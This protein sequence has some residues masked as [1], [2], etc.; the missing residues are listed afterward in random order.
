M[1]RKKLS[2]FMLATAIGVG[3]IALTGCG[4]DTSK[5]NE[6]ETKKDT[7][8]VDLYGVDGKTK[9]ESIKVKSGEKI[10]PK[11]PQKDGY[12]FVAWYLT[13]N[14]ERRADLSKPIT[15]NM[16]LYAGLAKKQ[17]DTRTFYVVGSG[18][19]DV[20]K[21]SNWG[22]V[23][24]DAQKLEKKTVDG[25]NVYT[26][27]M[28]LKEGDQF[29]FAIDGS[30]ANQRGYGYFETNKKDGKEYFKNS[31]SL[32]NSSLKKSNIEVKVDGKYT[33]TLTTYPSDDYY[34]KED[35]HYKEESKENF[36][37]NPY[38]TITFDYLGK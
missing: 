38:D 5:A 10:N 11:E 33:F 25:K 31:G 35:E 30:W 21:E 3:T 20:L 16:R 7:L 4:T 14:H 22:K 19:S 1:L 36:N 12:D 23:T 26:I 15:E 29:Q 2:M 9:I 24:G 37:L 6:V 13:P 32:G 28:D 27:T 34:D 17:E 18:T 8:K